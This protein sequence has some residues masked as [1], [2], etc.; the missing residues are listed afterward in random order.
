M[1]CPFTSLPKL[2]PWCPRVSLMATCSTTTPTIKSEIL[3][4]L[5][6][7]IAEFTT[8][9]FED[10]CRTSTVKKVLS[11][12]GLFLL[13]AHPHLN[14]V[15]ILLRTFW[16]VIQNSQTFFYL[17]S[18]ARNCNRAQVPKKNCPENWSIWNLFNIPQVNSTNSIKKSEYLAKETLDS[19]GLAW[20]P[21]EEQSPRKK[22][23]L[24]CVLL[25][26]ILK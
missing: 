14:L 9:K 23:I 11:S 8:L 22:I 16:V 17:Y 4:Q 5:S 20:D 13:K 18:S 7:R 12:L 26:S 25:L 1:I 10:C 2:L 24:S 19:F 21:S 3:F 15:S 6:T